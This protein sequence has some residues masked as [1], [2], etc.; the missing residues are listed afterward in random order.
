M[1]E[2]ETETDSTHEVETTA[3]QQRQR[4]VL[5][6]TVG[7]VGLAGLLLQWTQSGAVARYMSDW[8]SWLE[9]IALLASFVGGYITAHFVRKTFS[10]ISAF[11]F[12]SVVGLI[13][14]CFISPIWGLIAGAGAGF[15]VVTFQDRSLR[16]MLEI[17]IVLSTS[18]A[19]G[20]LGRFA[21]VMLPTLGLL[22]AALL[23]GATCVFVLKL[24]HWFQL[25]E[26]R[27]RRR[28]AAV[29]FGQ[30]FVLFFGFI[31]W[32]LE[33][34]VYGSL[35][36][37]WVDFANLADYQH[38]WWFRGIPLVTVSIGNPN[39]VDLAHV[40]AMR[41]LQY[42][43]FTRL[44]ESAN[45]EMGE[46]QS[47]RAALLEGCDGKQV[48]QVIDAFP[49]LNYL[50]LQSPKGL[51]PLE[52]V[53]NS[54]IGSLVVEDA[55]LDQVD[56]ESIA[57]LPLVDFL[58]LNRGSMQ[59]IEIPESLRSSLTVLQMR[60]FNASDPVLTSW[61]ALPNLTTFT[62]EQPLPVEAVLKLAENKNLT[63]CSFSVQ[64]YTPEILRALASL[65]LQCTMFEVPCQCKEDCS[66]KED[67]EEMTQQLG[68]ERAAAK[69]SRENDESPGKLQ[70]VP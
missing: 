47:V 32:H 31:G 10:R 60:D 64:R 37:R 24:G 68:Q 29:V 56:L 49:R 13:L 17:I 69:A 18:F 8:Y 14:S 65:Q 19:A 33:M 7:L 9:P 38:D 35:R 30:F 43:D 22:L 16:T 40:R 58:Y 36:T 67:L 12:A 45:L 28:V 62:A 63:S 52:G 4:K 26:E 61:A 57:S 66:C 3:L 34:F 53:S 11:L 59:D 46:K 23:L 27:E 6:A 15:W 39:A 41:H 44:S 21:W 70:A 2:E 55:E 50:M 54:R 20:M 5:F 25:P 48:Q 42:V 51:G 1:F